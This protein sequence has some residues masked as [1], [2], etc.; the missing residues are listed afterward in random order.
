MM[1]T[2]YGLIQEE[3]DESPYIPRPT[4]KMRAQLTP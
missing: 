3:R 4:A 2:S 1:I